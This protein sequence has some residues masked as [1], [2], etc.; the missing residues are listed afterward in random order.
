MHVAPLDQQMMVRPGDIDVSV[1]DRRAVDGAW[2]AGN[3]PLLLT[4]SGR[5]LLVE[6]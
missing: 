2:V 5:M 3:G 1:L 4:M 6:E